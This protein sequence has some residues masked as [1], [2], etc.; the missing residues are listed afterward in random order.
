MTSFTGRPAS[1]DSRYATGASICEPL[2]P[3]SPPMCRLC[4]LI[5][6]G[7]TPKQAASCARSM[8]RLLLDAHTS[9]RPSAC[10]CASTACGSMN[11]WCSVGVWKVCSNT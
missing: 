8:Y 1:R 7:S 9:A 10:T 3:K 2:P 5:V 4:S 6:A 11:P